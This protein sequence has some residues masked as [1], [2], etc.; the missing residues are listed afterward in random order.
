MVTYPAMAGSPRDPGLRVDVTTPGWVTAILV[1]RNSARWVDV[2]LPTLFGQSHPHLDVIV[3]DNDSSDG[4]VA[5]I[6]SR[7]PKVQILE[8][9]ENAGFSRALNTGIRQA[10][11]EYILSLNFD[12]VL[13][14]DFI[15]ALVQGLAMRPDAGWAAGSMRKLTESGPSEAIDCNGHYLLRSRYCYGYDPEQP[16]PSH[17]ERPADVFGASGCAALYRRSMLEALA[18]DGEIFDED[19]FAYFEDIDVDWRAGRQGYRCI[20]VPEARGAHRRGGSGDGLSAQIVSLLLSNRFLVMLKNDE[21]DDVRRDLIPI[22]RRTLAD[23]RKYG[24][25]A[26][27]AVLTAAGRVARL[28]P[29]MLA[30]RRHIRRTQPRGVSPVKEFRLPT[31]FLG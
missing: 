15:T 27:R 13:E 31:A 21:P 26:P 11:G 16:Q 17:Y 28:A 29:R 23:I 19:L 2:V 4:S 5:A 10:Q 7:Y 9:K 6:R 12:V 1:N 30:K 8:L 18:I 3:V 14:P 24:R 22:V 25:S 20:Y